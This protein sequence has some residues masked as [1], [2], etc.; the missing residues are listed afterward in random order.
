MAHDSPVRFL[1]YLDAARIVTAS[2]DGFIR[3]W[4][5]DTVGTLPLTSYQHDA[6]ILAAALRVEGDTRLLA[7]ADQLGR[8]GQLNIE[9][10]TLS[11]LVTRTNPRRAASRWMEPSSSVVETTGGSRF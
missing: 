1:G 2:E 5:I 10:S 11:W 7:F 6:P 4:A 3:T 9:T 8:V